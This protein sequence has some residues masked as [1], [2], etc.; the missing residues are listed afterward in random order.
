MQIP[1]IEII[2][3]KDGAELLRKTMRPGDYVIGREPECKARVD[4]ERVSAARSRQPCGR[5]AQG[6]GLRPLKA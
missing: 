4:V 1:E 6:D 3:S 2:V 5:G